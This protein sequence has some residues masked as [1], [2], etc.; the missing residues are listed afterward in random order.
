MESQIQRTL[1]KLKF[2]VT[3]QEHKHS[4]PTSLQPGELCGTAKC[5]NSL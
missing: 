4:Y 5:A 3:G 1:E 2:K